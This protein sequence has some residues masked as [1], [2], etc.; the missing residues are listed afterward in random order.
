MGEIP[1]VYQMEN[2]LKLPPSESVT[3]LPCSTTLVVIMQ[4]LTSKQWSIVIAP[5]MRTCIPSSPTEMQ[6]V[7]VQMVTLHEHF[8]KQNVDLL[9]TNSVH[10]VV[11]FD[12]P[13]NFYGSS[14]HEC[15][16][17]L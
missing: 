4:Q 10:L 1:R 13:M 3:N 8:V 16:L 17:N 14:T 9:L 6:C 5:G 2:S 15:P 12:L 7:C 11:D